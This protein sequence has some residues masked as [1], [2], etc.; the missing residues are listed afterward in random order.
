MTVVV[1]V[2]VDVWKVSGYGMHDD[3][4]DHWSAHVPTP[5][6]VPFQKLI[7]QITQH[8]HLYNTAKPHHRGYRKQSLIRS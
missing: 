5:G 8:H 4:S 3:A 1:Q 2:D 6:R 7:W